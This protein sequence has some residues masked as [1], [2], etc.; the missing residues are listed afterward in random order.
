MPG[1]HLPGG[2]PAELSVLPQAWGPGPGSPRAGAL[3]SPPTAG[4]AHA[5][6]RGP[7]TPEPPPAARRASA[8]ALLA[9]RHLAPAPRRL[10]QSRAAEQRGRPGRSAGGRRRDLGGGEGGARRCPAGLPGPFRGLPRAARPR[11]PSPRRPAFPPGLRSGS[12]TPTA[13]PRTR[14]RGPRSPPRPPR[15]PRPG[16]AVPAPTSR[17]RP[18]GGPPARDFAPLPLG[19]SAPQ[20]PLPKLAARSSSVPSPL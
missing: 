13:T 2:D 14:L 5:G 3:H 11:E 16:Q 8:R 4:R 20:V 9:R 15:A 17:L 1:C 12:W 6:A 19:D 18:R 7:R 10:P